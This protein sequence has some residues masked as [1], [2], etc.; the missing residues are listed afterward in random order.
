MESN[1]NQQILEQLQQINQKID[2]YTH[3]GRKI[4]SNFLYGISRSLGYLIGTLIITLIIFY[5][6]SKLNLNQVI[7]NWIQSN[8]ANYQLSVPVPDQP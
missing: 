5:L 7:N 6:F 3:P 4:L 1:Q 8:L 2:K